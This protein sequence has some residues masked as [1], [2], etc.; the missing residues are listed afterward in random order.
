MN[1]FERDKQ[2]IKKLFQYF[3]WPVSLLLL[4]FSSIYLLFLNSLK[5]TQMF[6]QTFFSICSYTFFIY[7]FFIYYKLLSSM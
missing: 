1:F 2:L 4:A 3:F 7:L 5:A 6:A